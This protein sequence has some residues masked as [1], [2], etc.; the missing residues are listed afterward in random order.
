MADRT[1]RVSGMFTLAE[2]ESAIKFEEA[3]SFELIT[4]RI[5]N[6]KDNLVD[7]KKLALGDLPKDLKLTLDTDPAPPGYAV[8]PN[9]P[10][11]MMVE[12][13]KKNVKAWRQQ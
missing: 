9:T 7:F 10:L 4:W 2:I 6:N 3:K 11:P 12:G 5:E 13:A 1:S 8:L